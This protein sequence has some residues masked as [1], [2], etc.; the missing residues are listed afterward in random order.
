MH[1]LTDSYLRKLKFDAAQVSTLQ[2]LGEFRGKQALF[3]QQTPE[4][5]ESLKNAAIVESSESSNRIEGI[6]APH[7]RVEAVVAKDAQPENRSEQELAGYRDALRG[8]HSTGAQMRFSVATVR[9]LH[10]TMYLYMLENGGQWKKKNNEIIELHPDG[11]F[12]RVRFM[13]V[14][15]ADTPPA[16]QTLVTRYDHAEHALRIEPLVLIPLAMLDFLCIH[17]F[18]DGNGRVSRLLTLLLLYQHEYLVGRFISLERIV[19]ESKQTYY[20]VI[21]HSSRHWHEGRHDSLPWLNYFWGVLT[22]A[23]REFEER[24]GTIKRGKGAKTDAVR[25]TVLRQIAPFAI[26]DIEAACP[27]VSHDMIRLV[28]RQLRDEGAIKAEGLGRGAKW[29]VQ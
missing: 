27:W 17:P 9:E 19:E 29:R 8:I 16:M 13:P 15:A 1:S 10:K 5:L 21:E 25:E 11:S 7:H 26:S 28:L 22:R 2:T 20:E 4:V 23:Y 18:R 6:T 3:S 12:K 14:T 24:V